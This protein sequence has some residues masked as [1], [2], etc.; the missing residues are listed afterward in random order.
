MIGSSRKS[1]SKTD[2]IPVFRII[3]LQLIGTVTAAAIMLLLLDKVSAYSAL[4]GG[5]VCVIPSAF[6]AYRFVNA[7][8]MARN[9]VFG[10]LMLGELGKLIFTGILFALVFMFIEPLETLLFFV[11]FIGVQALHWFAPILIKTK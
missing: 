6:L 8:G 9:R 3:W 10:Y 1:A 4:L 11:T 2:S 5:M 7:L